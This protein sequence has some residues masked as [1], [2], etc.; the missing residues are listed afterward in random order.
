MTQVAAEIRRR[1]RPGDTLCVDGFIAP[2]YQMTGLRCPSRFL[3]GDGVGHSPAWQTEYARMLDETPP[4]FFVTFPNRPRVRRLMRRGY[5]RHDIRADGI[6]FSLLI[7]PREGE[8]ERT[9]RAGASRRGERPLTSPGG[10]GQ[11]PATIPAAM[12]PRVSIVVPLLDE[13]GTLEELHAK[14]TDGPRRAR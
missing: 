11:S 4:T 14:L 2:L 10:C 13:E 1:A 5:R 9:E 6:T 12:Q 3:I 7:R 8:A